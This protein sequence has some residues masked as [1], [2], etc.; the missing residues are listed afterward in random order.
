MQTFLATENQQRQAIGAHVPSAAPRD[1]IA[2][3]GERQREPVI[4][5][6]GAVGAHMSAFLEAIITRGQIPPET[7]GW[8]PAENHLRGARL[9]STFADLASD[10]PFHGRG[11][12]DAEQAS[13]N[14]AAIA[15]LDAWLKVDDNDEQADDWE[16]VKASLEAHRT[17]TRKLF[18]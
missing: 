2:I 7:H 10:H 16:R 3:G 9:G 8:S 4:V 6:A 13:K 15:L 1:V 17:S 11:V 14:E 18:P 12:V 5:G